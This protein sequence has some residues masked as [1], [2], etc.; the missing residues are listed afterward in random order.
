MLIGHV[1]VFAG[2]SIRDRSRFKVEQDLETRRLRREYRKE[3]VAPVVKQIDELMALSLKGSPLLGDTP[4]NDEAA[5]LWEGIRGS[6][7]HSSLITFAQLP[8][9]TDQLVASKIQELLVKLLRF[10]DASKTSSNQEYTNLRAEASD[11]YSAIESYVISK[12]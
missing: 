2:E 4:M 7:M 6:A 8:R 9:I 10:T 5:K 11:V 3:L 12:E 1:I